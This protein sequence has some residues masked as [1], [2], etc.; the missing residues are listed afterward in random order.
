MVP[1]GE[2]RDDLALNVL[3]NF[4]PLLSLLR[5]AGREK[6]AEIAWLDG[7]DDSSVGESVVIIR[8]CAVS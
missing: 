5:W 3:L 8:N 7:R 1:V 2:S 4:L 6:L